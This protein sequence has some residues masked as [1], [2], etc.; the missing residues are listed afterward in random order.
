MK[1]PHLRSLQSLTRGAA[2]LALLMLPRVTHAQDSIAAARNLYAA[3]AYDDALAVLNRLDASR[4]QP[5]RLAINQYRAFCLVALRRTGE[6]E[7]AI[8]AVLADQPLYHP[9]ESDASPRLMSVFT[10]VRQRMLPVILQQKYARGKAAFDRQEY[11]VAVEEFDQVLQMLGDADLGEA[12]G[13]P[14]LS[15][16]RMLTGG[17]RDLSAKAAVAAAAAAAPAQVS[18]PP[19]PVAVPSR[20]YFTGDAGVS[21]PV[22]VRQDVP[23]FPQGAVAAGR[24]V[25][26]VVINEAGMVETAV[27][28]TPVHPR[29]DSMVIAATKGWRFKP[30][31]VAGTPVKF[32]KY[33]TISVK[34]AG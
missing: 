4:S 22:I 24:G 30:A 31:T 25:L 12:V 2:F 32:R 20:I 18:A 29:F 9:A 14:P 15:D 23:S 1:T 13:R 34:P 11:A 17:F 10:T 7:Q 33:I 19:M 8:E 5:D 6:A 26:E 16:L 27:M 3:A 21:P 28:R